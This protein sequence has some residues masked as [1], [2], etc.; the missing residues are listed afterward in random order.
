MR[1]LELRFISATASEAMARKVAAENIFAKTMAGIVKIELFV[2]LMET[3]DNLDQRIK[4][5]RHVYVSENGKE[6]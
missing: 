4:S 6:S 5:N 2:D 1:N 3:K